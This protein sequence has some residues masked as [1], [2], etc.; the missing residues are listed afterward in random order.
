M[1]SFEDHIIIPY[2][3]PSY[4]GSHKVEGSE[5]SNKGSRN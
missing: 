2:D 3:A 5:E 4:T 1:A